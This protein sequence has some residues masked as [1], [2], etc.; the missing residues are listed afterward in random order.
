MRQFPSNSQVLIRRR[1]YW[2][3]LRCVLALRLSLTLPWNQGEKLAECLL[4][5]IRPVSELYEY[6][7]FFLLRRLLAEIC[8]TELPDNGSFLLFTNHGLQ[9]RLVKGKHRRMMFVYRQEARK[10]V[11]VALF[12]NRQFQR[13]SRKLMS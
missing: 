11:K 7:C 6:W 12:Y 3:V 5:D 10:A 4:G 2:D 1:G 13:P 8:Q 9:L